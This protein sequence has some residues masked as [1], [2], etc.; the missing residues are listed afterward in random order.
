MTRLVVAPD[1][2]G[3]WYLQAGEQKFVCAIG[4]N[5]VTT[6]KCEGDGKSP[7]GRYTILYGFYRADRLAA[8]DS[9]LPFTPI[10]KTMGWCDDPAHSDYN[11]LVTLP[12]LHSH[13][14]LWRDDHLYDLVLVISHNQNPIIRGKG[15]AV[16]LHIAKPDYAGTEGC[17]AMALDDWQ[18]LLPNLK[19]G[20]EIIISIS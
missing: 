17:V 5:G 2:N 13:E 1:P 14:K 8:P 11:K 9:H 6:D 16:F 7:A 10:E 12:F 15:S 19:S 4:K 18:S 20:D 3:R